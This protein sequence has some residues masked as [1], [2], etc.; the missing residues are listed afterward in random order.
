M[1][2][3][4]NNLPND[5]IG[6]NFNVIMM[7]LDPMIGESVLLNADDSYTIIINSRLS[8]QMQRECF[9]HAIDHVRHKDWESGMTADEIERK[10]HEDFKN[11]ERILQNGDLPWN[12]YSDWQED[13]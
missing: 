11:E 7:D 3:T 2:L 1:I 5:L 13:F 8:S 6:Y 12:G 4:S 9:Y 10:R